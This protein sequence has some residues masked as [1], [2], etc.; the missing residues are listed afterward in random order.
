MG[1]LKLD[2]WHSDHAGK[3]VDEAIEGYANMRRQYI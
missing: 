3:T 2:S 1:I